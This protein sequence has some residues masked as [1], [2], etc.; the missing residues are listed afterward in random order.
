MIGTILEII[1]AIVVA[2]AVIAT[3]IAYTDLHARRPEPENPETPD[4]KL[5]RKPSTKQPT[6]SSNNVSNHRRR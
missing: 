1:G 2:V 3:V 4:V 6:R 5:F